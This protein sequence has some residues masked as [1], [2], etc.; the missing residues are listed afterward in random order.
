MA[1]NWDL[2]NKRLNV[3]GNTKRERDIN[4]LKSDLLINVVN[5]PSHKT[6]T[7]NGVSKG[8]L[9]NLASSSSYTNLNIKN[10]QS[11]NTNGFKVGDYV[12]L[13]SLNYLINEVDPEDEIYTKGKMQECNYTLNFLD[14]HNLPISR[15]CIVSNSSGGVTQDKMMSLGD[16]KYSIKLPF[17]TETVL[18]EK[19]RRLLI[20]YGTL[21][22]IA[23]KIVRSDR[24][25]YKYGTGGII[26]LTV[27][28]DERNSNDNIPLMIADYYSNVAPTP[29]P[30]ELCTI[31]YTGDAELQTGIGY[32]KFTAIF[33]DAEGNILDNVIPVWSVVLTDSSLLQYI[34]T[35]SADDYIKIKVTSTKMIGVPVRLELKDVA[36]TMSSFVILEVVSI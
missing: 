4:K 19:D 32:K 3:N 23:Y 35:E 12:V 27:E 21:K 20:D 10:I 13:D 6:V 29:P 28:E 15:P 1:T 33:K 2:Y 22:P 17:D 31:T 5:S 8:L 34:S 18:L 36:E 14:S 30:I 11:L 9:V 24:V 25:S 26:E 7:I 16:G